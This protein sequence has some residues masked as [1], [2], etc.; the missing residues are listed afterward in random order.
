MGYGPYGA[1]FCG[2]G[3]RHSSRGRQRHVI[4]SLW[5]EHSMPFMPDEMVAMVAMI[6]AVVV[7]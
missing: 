7:T 6:V 5:C 3:C 2:C 1:C 4:A